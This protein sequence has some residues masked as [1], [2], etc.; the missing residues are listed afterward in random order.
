[1]AKQRIIFFLIVI[2]FLGILP[3]SAQNTAGS[4]PGEWGILFESG[5][6]GRSGLYWMSPDAKTVTEIVSYDTL[7][8]SY[9]GFTNGFNLSPDGTQ[10]ALSVSR[11]SFDPPSSAPSGIYLFLP[12]TTQSQSVFLYTDNTSIAPVSWSPDGKMLAFCTVSVARETDQSL[13]IVNLETHKITTVLQPWLIF[14]WN[15]G[16]ASTE[17]DGCANWLNDNTLIFTAKISPLAADLNL[18]SPYSALFEV[19]PDGS[20]LRQITPAGVDVSFSL[21]GMGSIQLIKEKDEVDYM[22]QTDPMA[23]LTVNKICQMNLQTFET[24]QIVDLADFGLSSQ[25]GLFPVTPDGEIGEDESGSSQALTT[26]GKIVTALDAAPDGRIVLGILPTSTNIGEI[27]LYD[28]A[29]NTMTDL[30]EG[31]YPRWFYR[32][33]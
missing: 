10:I 8:K 25:T 29:P 19:A 16:K 12:A 4:S 7:F 13:N 33:P 30:G 11:M 3:V 27:E 2:G 5:A 20:D 17:L 1:M 26:E 24:H 22:C 23:P 9:P 32:T 15:G 18:A 6:N 31:S 21:F 14:D 28:P